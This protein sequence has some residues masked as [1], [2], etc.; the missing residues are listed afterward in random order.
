MGLKDELNLSREGFD[1]MVAMWSYMLP[2]THIMSKNLYESEKLLLALKMPYD[3]IHVCQA[4][5][6][7]RAFGAFGF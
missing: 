5:R 3:K 2:A 1:K 6:Y 4:V 7:S